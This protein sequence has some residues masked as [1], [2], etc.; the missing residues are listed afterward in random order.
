MS[1]ESVSQIAHIVKIDWSPV[2][3]IGLNRSGKVIM[4]FIHVRK[5]VLPMDQCATNVHK[6]PI[7]QES[8]YQHVK[9]STLK[10]ARTALASETPK[11]AFQSDIIVMQKC[12]ARYNFRASSDSELGSY[13]LIMRGK[14]I[15]SMPNTRWSNVGLGRSGDISGQVARC[16]CQRPSLLLRLCRFQEIPL[17]LCPH[18]SFGSLR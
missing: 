11:H 6:L 4:N 12:I 17:H 3:K 14:S 13:H 5:N 7:D 15:C 18:S 16:W 1:A 2:V 9:P 10:L 8:P